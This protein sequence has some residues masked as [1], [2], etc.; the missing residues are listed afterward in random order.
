[1]KTELNFTN[2]RNVLVGAIKEPFAWPGGYEKLIVTDEGGLLCHD[3]TKK[4]ARRIMADIRD[5][6]NTGWYPAG[7]VLEMVS[8]D[9]SPDDCKSYCDHCGKEIGEIGC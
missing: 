6:Y 9:C 5:G 2:A 8:P 1:M 7:T 3:C 4:E